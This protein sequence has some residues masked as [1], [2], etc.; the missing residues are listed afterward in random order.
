MLDF[1]KLDWTACPRSLSALP[2]TARTNP[3]AN[4]ALSPRL[5]VRELPT[6]ALP[7]SRGYLAS[8]RKLPTALP[9]FLSR[10]AT[11]PA[12]SLDAHKPR[13]TRRLPL[14]ALLPARAHLITSPMDP[15]AHFLPCDA[16]CAT[17]KPGSTP[18]CRKTAQAA[19]RDETSTLADDAPQPREAALAA[20]FAECVQG[21]I[22]LRHASNRLAS[23]VHATRAQHTQ[24][25]VAAGAARAHALSAARRRFSDAPQTRHALRIVKR[26]SAGTR[27]TGRE[28]VVH[29][30]ARRRVHFLDEV[31]G[32]STV[33]GGSCR[34]TYG[35]EKE[36]K[37]D[38]G[39]HESG[40]ARI[41]NRRNH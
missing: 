28:E 37:R 18:S 6:A 10:L 9:A 30:E 7:E 12:W 29:E 16:L 34:R 38:N 39:L 25:A 1:S 40:K 13:P 4:I 21:E 15:R 33:D 2:N 32:S 11:C 36:D 20:L 35:S 24:K 19:A 23:I 3:G 27:G 26:T 41:Q 8:S 5:T 17:P 31:G 14:E 22:V